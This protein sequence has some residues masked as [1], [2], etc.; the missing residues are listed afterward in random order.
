[1]QYISTEAVVTLLGGAQLL[2]RAQPVIQFRRIFIYEHNINKGVHDKNKLARI[3]K[4]FVP[5]FSRDCENF[6][7]T[8]FVIPFWNHQ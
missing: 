3:F 5:L 1:M 6:H 7:S 2:G 4:S 8:K